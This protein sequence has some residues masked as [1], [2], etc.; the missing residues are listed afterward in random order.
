MVLNI[1]IPREVLIKKALN[2]TLNSVS[3]NWNT[4]FYVKLN[5]CGNGDYTFDI[6]YLF[7]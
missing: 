6:S 7:A 4:N 1:I 2:E 3:R 5:L